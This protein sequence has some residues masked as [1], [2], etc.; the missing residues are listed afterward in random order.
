MYKGT[1]EDVVRGMYRI[2]KK[3]D[4]VN[5]K[6]VKKDFD[7][8]KDK[9]ID[10]DGDVD[11]SDKYL[12]KRRKAVSKA[13]KGEN[14]MTKG[15]KDDIDVNP[16]IPD[17][18]VKEDGHVDVAS[19]IRKCKTSIEDASQ[20]M[21]KL[22]TMDPEGSL[23]TW[24]TNKLAVACMSLNKLR[25]YILTSS[26]SIQEKKDEVK[27]PDKM[28][29]AMDKIV[30]QLTKS[31]KA[32]AKQAD[33]LKKIADKDKI[34]EKH[35]GDHM[36]TG[37]KMTDAEM[38]KREDIKKGLMKSKSDF[39]DRYGKDA[40]QVMNAL[41]T[42]KAMEA[43]EAMS[44]AQQAAIAI[45]KKEK[46]MKPKNEEPDEGNAFSAALMAAREKGEKTFVV[47]GKKYNVEDIIRKA[48][49][50]MV[51]VKDPN[52]GKMIMKKVHPETQS[53]KFNESVNEDMN[54]K[55][56]IEGLPDFF[57]SAKNPGEVKLKMRKMLK[58]PDM[59]SNVE[60][61]PDAAMKK[62]FRLKAQGKDEEQPMK[63]EVMSE[64]KKVV[65]ENKLVQ[66][67]S[68]ILSNKSFN[69]FRNVNEKM[70]S[71]EKMAKGLYNEK[72]MKDKGPGSED[73][74]AKSIQKA[75]M[76]HDGEKNVKQGA[77]DL[78]MCAKDVMHE[79]YGRG[80]VIHGMHSDPDEN[81]HVSHYDIMFNHGIE[82]DMPIAECE[83]INERMHGHKM[84]KK[85]K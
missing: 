1:L 43:N 55:V 73:A 28:S 10:N 60:R 22:K 21:N 7:D 26:E 68:D 18:M 47:S 25:D 13:I 44:R 29:K 23:P 19:S 56:S 69:S 42:K 83:V 41:A 74:G 85:D 62:H 36:S 5:P 12:H 78:H 81:G 77:S 9:D 53:S 61:V 45:S 66:A 64:E 49:V 6:A 2:E 37:R 14:K 80:N 31:V 30:G 67:V 34:D 52:T 59:L 15:K 48:D 65:S 63:E 8:R 76:K 58:K 16:K 46:G 17:Q 57:V 39:K 51:K 20:I 32:H 54:Y 50:K 71:K 79:K 33:K 27:M 72:G 70:S 35:G 38:K 24:W 3:L 4:P 84:K 82:K 40:D 75:N 11:S